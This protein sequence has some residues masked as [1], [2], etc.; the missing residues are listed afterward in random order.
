MNSSAQIASSSLLSRLLTLP[1]AT[2]LLFLACREMLKVPCW[3]LFFVAAIVAWPIWHYQ[4][5]YLLFQR[6]AVL[7][8][9]TTEDSRLRRWLWAG[10]LSRALQ[11]LTALG[12]ALLL[13]GF[14]VLLEPP[15]WLVLAGDTLLLAMVVG[16][17]RRRLATQ[18]RER[19]LGVLVRRWPLMLFNLLVLSVGFLLVDFFIVG[20]PDTRGM[21]W[22]AVAEQA[23]GEVVAEADCPGS[24]LLVGLLAV[25]ERLGWHLSE[26][27][28]P[29]LPEQFKL[30]AWGLFLLQAGLLAYGFTRLQLGV[31]GLLDARKLRL[32]S[33]TGETTFSRT[34]VLTILVLALFYLYAMFKLRDFD[35]SELQQQAQQVLGWADPCKPDV[36]ALAALDKAFDSELD[37]ARRDAKQAAKE[38][39]D[40]SLDELFDDVENGVDAYLD[41]YFTVVGEYQRLAA[42]AT[43]D[44]GELMATELEKQL[45]DE[46]QFDNRLAASSQSIAA[47]SETRMQDLRRRL[48]QQADTQFQANP[49]GLGSLDLAAFG[50]LDRDGQRASAAVGGGAVVAVVS[51]KLLAKKTAAAVVGKVAMKKSFVTAAGVIGKASAKKGG[52]ILLSA[53]GGAAV[54]APGG[55]LAAV[56]GIVAGAAAW[57]AFDKAFVEIDEALFRDQMRADILETLNKQRR[58]LA[59]ALKL[60][61]AAAID[62]MAADIQATGERLF[63]PARDGL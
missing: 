50:D 61:H 20:A 24:G 9:A 31:V 23:L 33:L 52:S 47:A 39:L 26:V 44:L 10:K 53:A 13:L 6:R 3:G 5:E 28:I 7:A 41:W 14:G 62:A 15:H 8:R 46:I 34:F 12:W 56:C 27:L 37:S 40:S 51:T 36:A 17:L 49:C 1:V 25:A 18:V 60:Q 43:G 29:R 55:P 4:Q 16:P 2:V 57:L 59:D 21:T 45:F 58:E 11:V 35:P 48:G 19:Q 63:L 38:R 42:A 32:Q 54:C 22:H 30:L